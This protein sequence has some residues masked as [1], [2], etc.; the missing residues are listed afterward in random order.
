MSD[1]ENPDIL[2]IVPGFSHDQLECWIPTL[3][4]ED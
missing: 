3:A 1:I 2:E 4:T